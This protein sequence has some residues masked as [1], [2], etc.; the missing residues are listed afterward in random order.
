MYLC[1]SIQEPWYLESVA[2]LEYGAS[3]EAT[4]MG[5]TSNTVT[6]IIRLLKVYPDGL[7]NRYELSSRSLGEIP[8]NVEH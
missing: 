4:T 8:S 7:C 5:M 3:Q 2:S 6:L 1:L